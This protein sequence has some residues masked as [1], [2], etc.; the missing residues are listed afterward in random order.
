MYAQLRSVGFSAL[1]ALSALSCRGGGGVDTAGLLDGDGDGVIAA[2]DCNDGDPNIGPGAIEVCDGIDND[3]S[4]GI[5]DN[6][7]NATS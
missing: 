1:L 7:T 4:G 2:E 5:D 3:C 6:A